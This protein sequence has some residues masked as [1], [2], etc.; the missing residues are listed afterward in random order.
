[1]AEAADAMAKRYD[2][3]VIAL[4][5]HEAP[6]ALDEFVREGNRFLVDVAPWAMSKDASRRQELADILYHATEALRVAAVFASPVM[7]RG[8]DRLWAQ[9]GLPG[10]AA[11]QRLPGAAAWGGLQPGTRT[12]RGESL[13]PR[14]EE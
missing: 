12:S 7:P 9:L 14:L 6:A 4:E 8:A 3:G 10:S 13:F 5:L 1:M 11:A 2:A